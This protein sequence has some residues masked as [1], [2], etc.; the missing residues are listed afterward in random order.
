MLNLIK[1]DLHRMFHSP[2]T[3]IILAFSVALAVFNVIATNLDIQ[4]IAENP[5][6]AQLV[7]S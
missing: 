4:S 5:Q 3:W 7:Q 2:S 6:S 1:M